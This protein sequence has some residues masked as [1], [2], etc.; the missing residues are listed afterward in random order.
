MQTSLALGSHL[1]TVTEEQ[2][3]GD[4]VIPQETLGYAK[5]GLVGESEG[6]FFDFTHYAAVQIEGPDAADFLQR[7]STVQMKKQGIGDCAYGAFLTGR[8]QPIAIGLFWRVSEHCYRILVPPTQRASLEAHIEQFHFGEKFTLSDASGLVGIFATWKR[9]LGPSQDQVQW[10]DPRRPQLVWVMVPRSETA[11]L[12]SRMASGGWTL[13]GHRLFDFYRVRAGVP[14]LGREL[15]KTDL[16]LE[17]NF[18]EVVA[19]NK[20]C[21]PG[22]E[23]VERIFTYGQ[24]NR[25]LCP[26]E[27][28]G[29]RTFPLILPYSVVIE[30]KTV[31]QLLSCVESPEDSNQAWGLGFVDKAHCNLQ[32]GPKKTWIEPESKLSFTLRLDR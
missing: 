3:C 24:V 25:K 26:V 4:F 19:R 8:A 29:L 14:E 5:E 28:T 22:Q 6:G 11:N 30:G 9:K 1:F 31:I 13:L 2:T 17:G 15:K 7:M 27:I 16:I 21:Y 10:Q 12:L 23:V 20:G 32:A 18:D